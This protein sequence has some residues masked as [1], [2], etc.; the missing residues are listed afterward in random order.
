MMMAVGGRTGGERRR[1]R[2]RTR[3]RTLSI[4]AAKCRVTA[5][6]ESTIPFIHSMGDNKEAVA[7]AAVA[8]DKKTKSR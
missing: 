7:V 8:L 5:R 6:I 4:V 3:T 2:R 1:R